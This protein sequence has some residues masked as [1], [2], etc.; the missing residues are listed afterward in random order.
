ML[1][2]QRQV[3]ENEII[4][5]CLPSHTTHFLQP[6]DRPFFKPLKTF[7]QKAVTNWIIGHPGRRLI[8]YQFGDLLYNAQNLAATINNGTSGF[9]A[10]GIFSYNP[11]QIPEYS[12]GI[13][14]VSKTLQNN[15]PENKEP[16]TLL[17][18]SQL[19]LIN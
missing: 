14:S 4:L 5:L 10:C 19:M 18:N 9:R 2:W 17:I 3:T 13:S 12:F 1:K 16:D 8:R 15:Q 7:W 11:E 6:L